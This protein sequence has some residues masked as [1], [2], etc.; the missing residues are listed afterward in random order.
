[1]AGWPSRATRSPTSSQETSDL[2]GKTYTVQYFER[3]VFEFHPENAA[4]PMT[5]LLAQLGTYRLHDKY[6]TGAPAPS[7]GLIPFPAARRVNSL[8][9]TSATE[10]WA[11]GAGIL[12]YKDGQWTQVTASTA[13][14]YLEDV[15]QVSPT[16]AWAVGMGQILHYSGGQWH[17]TPPRC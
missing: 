11:V 9:M 7:T 10:G 6:P 14:Q 4:P 1:M 15:A 13:D 8:K 17:P 16:E 3:A 12:H 5:F 2:D